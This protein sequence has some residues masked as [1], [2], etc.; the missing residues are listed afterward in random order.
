VDQAEVERFWALARSQARIT[1][2]PGYFGPTTV[3]VV[4]P[5]ATRV[6]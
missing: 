2:M 1:S 5:P 4:T 3:E 6:P